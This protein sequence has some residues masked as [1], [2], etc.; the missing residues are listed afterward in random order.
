VARCEGLRQRREP[1][2]LPCPPAG[3]RRH[4]LSFPS[5]GAIGLLS[6]GHAR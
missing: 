5:P 2:G 6:E 3:F 4:V 1:P